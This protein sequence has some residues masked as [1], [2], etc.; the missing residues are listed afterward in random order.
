MVLMGYF[1]YSKNTSFMAGLTVAQI[2][3]FSLILIALGVKVGHIQGEILSF[4][5][6]I[7]LVT[8]AGSTYLIKYSEKIYPRLSN[9]L[10]IF[11]REKTKEDVSMGKKHYDYI[12][13]GENRIG[14]SIMKLFMG[15]KKSYLVVDFNP[16]RVK[17]LKARGVN[18]IYGDVSNTEFLENI[19]IKKSKVVVSTIPEIDTNLMI[20][21]L[22]KKM[23]KNI[24]II[25]TAR[26]ISEAFK[27]YDEGAD[28]VILPHFLGG[29][30]TAQIIE[31]NKDSKIEYEI[32]KQRHIKELKERIKEGQEH[33][34]TEKDRV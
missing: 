31:K 26:H 7:G 8:I 14:F 3:E 4:V 13:F 21:R 17:K 23:N 30:Y 10:N 25:V 11:E 15:M 34:K 24:V 16:E 32:E 5:T 6:L 9:Y 22:L 20:L 1:G 33:P 27:L 2:S 12:L 19:N 28:Y 18:C 29:Q